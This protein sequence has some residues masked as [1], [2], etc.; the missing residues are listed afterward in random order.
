MVI[1]MDV[2]TL[3]AGRAVDHLKPDG[4]FGSF[5]HKLVPTREALRGDAQNDVVEGVSHAVLKKPGGRR[6][7]DA[8]GTNSESRPIV[9]GDRWK[10]STSF[11]T[12]AYGESMNRLSARA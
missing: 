9:P 12:P 2:V 8:T 10:V 11:C 1:E 5:A 7:T 4:V 3:M 6:A